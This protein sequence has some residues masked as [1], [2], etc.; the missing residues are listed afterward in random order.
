MKLQLDKPYLSI[1]QLNAIEIPDF[2]VL[3]GVNGSEKSHLLEAIAKRN[4]IIE[5]QVDANIVIF[6]YTTFRLENEKKFT[7][8]QLLNERE[9][10][11]KLYQQRVQKLVLKWKQTNDDKYSSL[12]L[13]CDS[14]GCSFWSLDSEDVLKYK[15]LLRFIFNS[16]TNKI[17][18]IM[19]SIFSLAKT[20]PFSI[21]EIEY[22][23][24][25]NLY[26]P[27]GFKSNFL[28]D[29][30]GKIFWDYH[31]KYRDNL[32]NLYENERNETNLDALPESAFIQRHGAKPWDLI[33][34]ILES[35]SSLQYKVNSPDGMGQL[36]TFQLRLRHNANQKLEIEFD[37]LSSGEKI[38][39]ALVASVYKSASDNHFPDVLLLDEIDASL[40]PLMIKNM[41]DVIQNTFCKQG[42]KVLLVTHSPTTIALVDEDSVFVVN[43]SG[44]ERIEKKSKSD[45]LSILTQGFATLESG[46]KL[47]DEVAKSNTTIITEGN[48]SS[49][50]TKAIK[51]HGVNDV[52]VLTGIERSSGKNQ[53]GTLFDFFSKVDH[54]NKVIFVFDCDVSS[55][56]QSIGNTFIFVLP[57]N[58]SNTLVKS[59]IENIFPVHLFDNFQKIIKRSD[60][61]EIIE[62]DES[63]KRDLEQ[64]ILDRNN[65]DDFFNF[66]SMIDEIKR[67]QSS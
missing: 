53:L 60:K 27:Y 37:Q 65:K 61:T 30:L 67:I 47:F 40:H 38:L 25:V 42:I 51:L 48:N 8:L 46:L 41:L 6:N 23:Q 2:T 26:K 16:A 45:A 14:T 34:E 9:Q 63:R 24:F 35:F 31:I 11:W 36:A 64:Y 29:Q 55:S 13:I 56:R 52:T 49:L 54:K 10:A 12:K 15:E 3:T 18:A 39:M 1:Q 22:E 57:K 32:L 7:P 43:P 62:F 21:D 59:G 4:I 19:Q 20:I 33:N 28:P 66:S 58:T 44:E 50:I 17:N 5:G